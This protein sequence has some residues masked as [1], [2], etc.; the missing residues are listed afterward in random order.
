MNNIP[1][2]DPYSPQADFTASNVFWTSL[3]G[4][5]VNFTREENPTLKSGDE[6]VIMMPLAGG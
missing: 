4:A 2:L 1:Q 3:K 6:L 5:M